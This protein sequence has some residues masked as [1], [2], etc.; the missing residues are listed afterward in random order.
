MKSRKL[1]R[2]D[3]L[4]LSGL[5]ASSVVLSAWPGAS[6]GARGSSLPNIILIMADALRADHVSAY[7][8]GR[9]TT[10]NLDSFIAS[11]GARF[12]EATTTCPWTY[13]ANAA[14]HTGRTPVSLNANWNNVYLPDD[15][16]TLAEYLHMAGY[17]T[18]GFVSAPFVKG[19]YGFTRGFDLYNDSVAYGHPTSSQGVASEVNALALNW[20]QNSWA[21]GQPLFLYLYYF[22]PHT[23]YNP[24]PPYD[25]LYDSTYTG[26]LTPDVYRDGQ[27]VVGGLIV[28]S[29]RD[30][31]HILA[32]Y[33][34]EITYFD[35]QLGEILTYLHTSNFLSNALVIATSD[36]GDMFGE[37]GRWT[38]GNALYEEVL[39]VPLLM[40]YPGVIAPGLVVNAP[41]Q[42]MDLMPSILDWAGITIPTEVQAVSLR[43]LAEG[44]TMPPRDIFSEQDGMMDPNGWAAWIAPYENLRAVK[45]N[46][47][48]FIHHQGF[49]DAD[50]LYLLNAGSLYESD[51]QVLSQSLLA[52]ELLQ[53]VL[54][55]YGPD[56]TRVYLP[57][58]GQ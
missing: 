9:A 56:P 36:H 23:W 52:Q 57:K 25:S 17:Y 24:L 48:K 5:T 30:I 26:T 20:L 39:R 1:T 49:S 44:G 47:W 40:R 50:E 42:N 45:R 55:F 12:A 22:D 53:A 43:S 38:H 7:G 15:A 11:Q 35:F 41:V 2:R 58:T 29:A 31:E 13:P 3:F 16:Q 37:H 27:D 14:I 51:N 19:V 21:G 46:G 4:R 18:A 33:D 28:P 10:P 54:D 6:V 34:G 8:Y 32:L